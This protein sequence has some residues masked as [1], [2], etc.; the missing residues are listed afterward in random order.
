MAYIYQYEVNER[1][2]DMRYQNKIDLREYR[3]SIEAVLREQFGELLKE[4]FID[5]DYIEFKLYESVSNG[6]LRAFGKKLK[7]KTNI[8]GFRR[9]RQQIYFMVSRVSEDKQTIEVD[10]I[11]SCID[12][13]EQFEERAE[14]FFYTA[15][16]EGKLSLQ[17][18]NVDR[19]LRNN[20]YVDVYSSVVSKNIF[21]DVTQEI[22]EG[23]W[24][25]ADAIHRRLKIENNEGEDRRNLIEIQSMYI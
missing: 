9:K 15:L 23:D 22:S 6:K 11:D 7:K 16:Q 12:Q 10:I 19:I 21:T 13:K 5:Y 18:G 4:I 20:F 8:R 24:F 14:R 17:E 25:Y 3:E 1:K 2:N